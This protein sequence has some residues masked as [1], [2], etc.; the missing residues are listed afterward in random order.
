MGGIPYQTRGKSQVIARSQL[1]LCISPGL[2]EALF[3]AGQQTEN[4]TI[5]RANRHLSLTLE[6]GESSR[7]I[8]SDGRFHGQQ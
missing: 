6:P 2:A 5:S 8:E 7:S 1:F 4:P 3:Y